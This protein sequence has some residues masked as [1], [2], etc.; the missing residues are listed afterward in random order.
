MDGIVWAV[1]CVFFFAAGFVYGKHIEASKNPAKKYD[2]LD[3]E[4]L[5][6]QKDLKLFKEEPRDISYMKEELRIERETKKKLVEQYETE[7]NYYKKLLD[8]SQA[9]F[10]GKIV[11]FR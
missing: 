2:E 10:D 5:E 8:K 3:G 6:N 11:R 4:D 1:L 7:I 9:N